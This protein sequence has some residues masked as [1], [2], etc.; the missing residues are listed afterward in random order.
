[1]LGN[2]DTTYHTLAIENGADPK[3]LDEHKFSLPWELEASG[4]GGVDL[5]SLALNAYPLSTHGE[6]VGRGR[7][8][9]ARRFLI[10]PADPGCPGPYPG[11]RVRSHGPRY[12]SPPS[13][14]GVFVYFTLR[15]DVLRRPLVLVSQPALFI[16]EARNCLPRNKKAFRETSGVNSSP[17]ASLRRLQASTPFCA[18]PLRPARVHLDK[19]RSP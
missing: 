2:A 11:L 17:L 18:A 10:V 13:L 6:G 1:M 19:R 14:P 3:V 8:L 7:F 5:G 4:S 9:F 16:Y 12:P 15:F